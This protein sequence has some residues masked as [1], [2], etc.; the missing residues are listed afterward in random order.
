MA[1]IVLLLL[2]VWRLQNVLFS[3]TYWQLPLGRRHD[4]NTSQ[5]SDLCKNVSLVVFAC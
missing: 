5:R 1:V 4:D 3:V 2:S